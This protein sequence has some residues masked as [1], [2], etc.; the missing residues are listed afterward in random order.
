VRACVH[1][2]VFK[3]EIGQLAW[4]I[5]VIFLALFLSV[6]VNVPVGFLVVKKSVAVNR[7]AATSGKKKSMKVV[8]FD[9]P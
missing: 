2:R 5:E 3:K 8:R 4:I 9:L 1:T 6:I 7:N